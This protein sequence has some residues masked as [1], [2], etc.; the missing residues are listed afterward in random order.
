[1]NEK[2]LIK[3]LEEMQKT[4][5]MSFTCPVCKDIIAFDNPKCDCGFLNPVQ[6]G[7]IEKKNINNHRW[8]T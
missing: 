6:N 4:G 5:D 7:A 1:M 3:I 2:L 8:L